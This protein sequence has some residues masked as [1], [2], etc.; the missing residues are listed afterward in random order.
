M[1][2]K[3][4]TWKAG[5]KIHA[6]ELNRIEE[7][8]ERALNIQTE[9]VIIEGPDIDDIEVIKRLY[10]NHST[11]FYNFGAYE[12]VPFEYAYIITH[13]SP[14]H[15]VLGGPQYDQVA[16]SLS[17]GTKGKAYKRTIAPDA[18]T[19]DEDNPIYKP[20]ETDWEEASYTREE[21]DKI[22]GNMGAYLGSSGSFPKNANNGD[23]CKVLKP[24]TIPSGK[25]SIPVNGVVWLGMNE[26]GYAIIYTESGSPINSFLLNVY[27]CTNGYTSN[28]SKYFG[29]LENADGVLE[30]SAQIEGAGSFIVN[31]TPGQIEKYL[32]N[33][34]NTTCYLGEMAELYPDLA[35]YELEKTCAPGSYFIKGKGDRWHL[36]SEPTK[37]A[38][39]V[40][41]GVV[42][43]LPASANDG[44]VYKVSSATWELHE[45]NVYID[46][47]WPSVSPSGIS[48]GR[49]GDSGTFSFGDAI[50][51]AAEKVGKIPAPLKIA[52]PSEGIEFIINYESQET[53]YYPPEGGP[54]EMYCS[55]N[56]AV[57]PS[58]NY[59]LPS[60]VSADI[61]CEKTETKTYIYYNG[62]FAE[63]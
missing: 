26:L 60:G 37:A 13:D 19:M 23:I 52:I 17:E 28:G 25:L 10:N 34:Q 9:S 32:V 14:S 1:S 12:H 63:L 48:L 2:F 49:N 20:A 31:A 62:A 16:I 6:S 53:T 8:V 58:G 15:A 44:E 5:E 51:A 36:L 7:G 11:A 24:C 43:S 33:G 40:F 29:Y 39:M 47:A 21:L 18:A 38:T 56:G 4:K 54:P 22:L 3:R 57:T 50:A 59:S 46:A 41:M 45:A 42:E 55:I 35:S 27:A 30:I 61:Y